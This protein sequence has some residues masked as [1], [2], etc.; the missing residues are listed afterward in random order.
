MT[1]D[2]GIAEVDLYAGTKTGKATV[3]AVA[4]GFAASVDVDFVAGAPSTVGLSVRPATVNPDGSVTVTATVTDTSGNAVVGET[5]LFQIMTNNSGGSFASASAVTNVNGDALVVYTAGPDTGTDTIRAVASSNQTAS[6]LTDIT[7]S[8]TA[9]VVGKVA[10][11]AGTDQLVADGTSHTTIQATV[12]DTNGDPVEGKTVTFSTTAGTLTG[13]GTT[14]TSTTDKN[15]LASVTLTAPTN[16]GT[17]TVRAEADGFIASV[18]ISCVAGP[19]DHFIYYVAPQTVIPG[20]TFH[21]DAIVEDANN[22]R[23]ENE[24]VTFILKKASDG[25]ILETRG[26]VTASDNVVRM[27]F[28]AL[29]G[30]EDIEVTLQ[31]NNGTTATFTVTV[32][33]T[34][35]IVSGVDI[36]HIGASTLPADGASETTIRAKVVDVSGNPASGIDVNF[37]TTSGTILTALPVTTDENGYAQVTLRSSTI[38]GT[39]SITAI[40]SG[41]R[42]SET[43]T[44]SDGAPAT[45]TVTANPANLTADGTST[46]QINIIV[47]DAYGNPINGETL[48]ASVDDGT[49][50]SLVLTTT[51][52]LASVQYTAPNSKPADGRATITIKTS[53]NVTGATDITLIG[54]QIASITLT[55][56]P[57]SLPADGSSQAVISAT[58]TLVGGGAV[59]DGTTVDFSIVDTVGNGNDTITSQAT[60][61][62]GVAL[63]T[64]T[65]DDS[66]GTATIRATAGGRTAEIRID[67]TPGSVSIIAVPNSI[68]GTGEESATITV[69][70]TDAT[71]A[72]DS[73]ETVSVV[74]DDLSLGSI[75]PQ[76]AVTNASGVATFTF[77][78]GT[79]G[80]TVTITA[81]YDPDDPDV[82]DGDDVTGSATIDIQA[83]PAFIEVADNYPEPT[84]INIK[85]TGGQSTSQIVFD[86]KDLSGNPVADGYR[87][88]FTILDGPDGG[89]AIEP[90]TA[91]TSDGKVATIL[92][93][94][95]KS[96]PVSIKATYYNDTNIS[97][98]VSQISI[99]AGPPVGEEFGIFA[100][101]LNISGLWKS[102]LENQVSVNVG[103]IYGNAV[104]DG[105]AINFKT[106]NTGGFFG[107]S[108]ANTEN[109]LASG[110]LHSGGTQTT[111]ANGFFTVTAEANNG[112]RTTHVTS[113]A[114]SP[115]NKA[116]MFI[117]T[118]GGGVYKSTDSGAS[119]INVSSSSEISGQNFIDPYI[120][121]I[122]IDPDHPDTVLAGT[123]YLGGGHI[124]RSLDGGQSWN[125][126]DPEE[127]N[128]LLSIGSA[129]L[130][131]L[132]DDSGS[133]YVW[134]GTDGMGAVFAPDGENFG[135]G[136]KVTAGPT[137]GAGNTGN[138]TMS[139][140]TLGLTAKSE[141][142]TAVFEK[143]GA[144]TSTPVFTGSDADGSL[145]SLSATST[146][147]NETWTLIYQGGFTGAADESNVTNP[148]S[149]ELHL[150]STSSTTRTETWKVECTDDT[151]GS[152]KFL[153]SGSVSGAQ[154]EA[155]INTNYSTTNGEVTF[156]IEGSGNF[157][158]GDYFTFDTAEDVWSV[159]G[160]SSGPQSNARTDVAY[161]SDNGEVSFT[162]TSGSRFYQHNDTWTFTTTATGDW[163]VTGTVSGVQIN[164][165]QTG[166]AYRS[167]N[168]EVSFTISQG[169]VGFVPG[170]SFTFTV[171]ESGLGFGSTVRK[172]VKATG[173]GAAAVLYAAT[174]QGVFKSADGG[175]TWQEVSNFAGDNVT[176]ISIHPLDIDT[177]YVGTIDAGVWYT[178]DAGATWNQFVSGLGEGI[179]ATVPVASATNTGN[180]VMSDVT[181]YPDSPDTQTE[182]WTVTCITA[183]Q[184]G[185]T[186]SVTGSV[187]GAQANYDLTTGVYTIP[188]VLSF[189]ITDGSTDFA[190]GD[191]FTFSTTRDPG[192]HI[193]DIAVY[194]DGANHYLYAV[195]YFNGSSEPH[196]VGNVY[197]ASLNAAADYAPTGSWAEAN[198]GLP[199]YDPPGDITLFAQHT[200]CVDDP[201]NPAAIFVGGE[202]INFYKAVS[203]LDTGSPAWFESKSG[204]TNRIMARMPI[205]FTGVCHM[206]IDEDSDGETVT[207]TV[208]IQDQNGNPPIS[209]STFTVTKKV[210]NK[211]TTL[212]NVTY[213]D[214]YTYTGTWSDPSDPST[215]NPY[216]ISTSIEDGMEVTFTFT[217]R[218]EDEVP[219]CSGGEETSTYNY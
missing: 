201:A 209:G 100:Q 9:Q 99:N 132:C 200:I 135:W 185:G 38:A 89:E 199:Q 192:M 178:T 48:T 40:A 160:F 137:P 22:N 181:V 63:A 46:S 58:L 183:A 159:T 195:T 96:G 212:A 113:I 204:L 64:L 144:S 72:P 33:P 81:S 169:S 152:E 55:A 176:A 156:W 5:V 59:P 7:V 131:V 82:D 35:T 10:I 14:V 78:G 19:A 208:Y 88:D 172:I 114:V 186:F 77:T 11:T 168:G 21:I 47:L 139:T 31:T 128:G 165:A 69:T 116:V 76:S 187:S 71:G 149:V 142:W 124:Y 94:G 87:I 27:D 18:D 219:G 122:A 188:G 148:A 24:Y 218:C 141:T 1:D 121:D 83:P 57:D 51:N 155:E 80:G 75:S 196:A 41:F 130:T 197:V 191:T 97:T 203:G 193:K 202:G 109:G 112:G 136:G 177:V 34:A 129:V 145:S 92:R 153:V 180:G 70:V 20:G 36:V 32:D 173:N 133:D 16:R 101:Y 134:A 62:G 118:D 98:T 182:N 158:V 198:T 151:P 25:T 194:D 86:V 49:L 54:Q 44:F 43:I 29:W 205:L 111:P 146:A 206:Y 163:V 215:N 93:S 37:T 90:T 103:D 157:V 53:N 60:T 170:D 104:P 95:T 120:N 161:T 42:D 143:T 4:S 30:D 108:V 213:P 154:P 127:W 74:I 147:G 175:L 52:G 115:A 189:S 167:D 119:W 162:I 3:T 84:S 15:G 140:P 126:N 66:P 107:P 39:A 184:N 105:T 26:D 8:A 138:G 61:S 190:V 211:T 79:S 150:V 67:Y 210:G 174:A 171:Q 23:L 73:G 179:R 214:V 85:G 2:N 17:T 68:L 28:T 216:V 50:S 106:Y 164:R 123:G 110:T 217:P 65:A 207:Y 91:L 6:V 12:T 56:S 125:S 117:G 166:T 102:N 13:G 45:V